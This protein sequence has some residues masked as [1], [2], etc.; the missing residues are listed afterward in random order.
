MSDSEPAPLV[1]RPRITLA[2]AL[3]IA[4]AALVPSLG[5]CGAPLLAEDASILGYVHRHGPL[6]DWTSTQYGLQTLRFWRPLVTS[7]WWLQERLFGVEPTALRAYNVLAHVATALLGGAVALRLG[8]GRAGALVAGAWIGLFPAQGGVVTWV[9]G[10]TDGTTG[11]LMLAAL[12][13]VLDRRAFAAALLAFLACAA[14]EMAFVL[15]AWGLAVCWARPRTG[16]AA[17]PG[18][19]RADL[20]P[21]VA[22]S[23]G[24]LVA[25][26]WRWQAVGAFVG[27]YP[28]EASGGFLTSFVRVARTLWSANGPSLAV[29]LALPLVVLAPLSRAARP[30]WAGLALAAAGCAPLVPLLLD[31]L[32][33][34]ANLRTLR[35]GDC[36]LALAAAT[37]LGAAHGRARS[38]AAVVLA[39]ALGH[40]GVLAWQD[41]HEWARAGE[42]AEA[43]V[44]R[45]RARVAGLPAGPEPVLV[46]GFPVAYEGAYALGFG[47]A[48]RFR[49]PF[50]VSPR[51]VWPLRSMFGLP[52]DE[53]RPAHHMEADGVLDVRTAALGV[54]AL[55]VS[56]G[57]GQ[58]LGALTV[59][60]SVTHEP[61]RSPLLVVGLGAESALEGSDLAAFE[62]LLVTEVGLASVAVRAAAGEDLSI[63]L[64]ALF[65]TSNGAVTLGEALTHAIDLGARRALLEVRALDA[66]G[67]VRAASPWV[68]LRWPPD[69]LEAVFGR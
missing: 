14:K 52:G 22:L 28:D 20:G 6:S 15:P 36:G 10:R 4:A 35:V 65:A 3:A 1:T 13:L 19:W 21:L 50:A 18:G 38:V 47:V 34:D 9:S 7:L 57:A 68:E 49:A 31:G 23:A 33:E 32:L 54:P 48:D 30:A 39:L 62:F 42:V 46:P 24:T 37:A 5:T 60:D 64:R 55:H 27:G 25:F 67:G 66:D 29:A 26:V 44:E 17:V 43:C 53:R 12:V 59:D 45:A 11:P 2:L 8:L 63:T 51:P 56:D 16:R 58:T 69:L 40:R 61:D 41:T